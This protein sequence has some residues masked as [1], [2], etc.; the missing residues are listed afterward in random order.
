[1][2]TN[3]LVTLINDDSKEIGTIIEID[4]A[5]TVWIQWP[6]MPNEALPHSKNE[7]VVVI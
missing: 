1:M 4:Y 3:D 5:G 7:L 6:D 2:E